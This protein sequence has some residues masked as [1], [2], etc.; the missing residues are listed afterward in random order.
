MPSNVM[1]FSDVKFKTR[2]F[3]VDV[4]VI[5]D[6]IRLKNDMELII[7]FFRLFVMHLCFTANNIS[8][9]DENLIGTKMMC[10]S[11]QC[12]CGNILDSMLFH[13]YYLCT[14]R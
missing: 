11:V 3:L 2:F 6:C 4:L 5:E 13:Y 8:W 9:I 14:K 10:I 1:L 7:L 12:A